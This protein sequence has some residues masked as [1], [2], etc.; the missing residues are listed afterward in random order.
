MAN[1][2]HIWINID[3]LFPLH[4]QQVQFTRPLKPP[5]S[6]Y[7]ILSRT[8]LNTA[9]RVNHKH[10]LERRADTSKTQEDKLMGQSTENAERRKYSVSFTSCS[11]GHFSLPFKASLLF[12]AG[13]QVDWMTL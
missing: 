12:K 8:L 2:N 3:Q 1:L 7:I 6:R 9:S 5:K 4:S 11:F 10:Q 13:F